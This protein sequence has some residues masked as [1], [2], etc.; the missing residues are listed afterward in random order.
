MEEDDIKSQFIGSLSDSNKADFWGDFRATDIDLREI[1]RN[2]RFRYEVFK[3]MGY[4]PHDAQKRFHDNFPYIE[5]VC[6]KKGLDPDCPHI[7]CTYRIDPK[8]PS[9]TTRVCANCKAE[10]RNVYHNRFRTV[11]AA[12]RWGKSLAV[13]KEGCLPL[14]WPG[15]NADGSLNVEKAP[16]AYVYA[17]SYAIGKHEFNYLVQGMESLGLSPERYNYSPA[18]G[19]LYARWPWG[20][21]LQVKS[22]QQPASIL[23]DEIDCALFAE[24]STLPML[25]FER[26]IRARMGSR[27]A[28]GILGSTPH[29]IG[30]FLETF[31]ERGQD[32]RDVE[33]WSESFSIM[34]NPHHPIED[35]EEARAMLDA[36]TFA[37]QYLGQFVTMAGLVFETFDRQVHV[38]PQIKNPEDLPRGSKVVFCIDFGRTAPTGALMGYWDKDG[39]FHALGE[40][41]VK[42][43]TIKTHFKEYLKDWLLKWNPEW[44]VY[45]FQQ[46]EA[47]Q[48]LQDEIFALQQM[49]LV[50]HNSLKMIPC[51][52]G[53]KAG[54]ERVRQLLHVNPETG[55]TKFY[56]DPSCV[57]LQYEFLH[58][59]NKKA[60]D[61]RIIDEPAPGH[62]HLMDAL[63][64]VAATS[65]EDAELRRDRVGMLDMED[66]Y[67]YEKRKPLS[68]HQEF[69][70]DLRRRAEEQAEEMEDD[71]DGE[72]EDEEDDYFTERTMD[73]EEW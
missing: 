37:E 43:K 58:Y 70:R 59:A 47:A 31:Y 22:W 23:G 50:D 11:I 60:P 73:Y 42:G 72:F 6:R 48:F 65:Y 7:E 4:E 15:I 2:A 54:I 62:D 16:R 19:N 39:A 53:K 14:L 57:N 5:E 35:V 61:G 55:F 12:A 56:C 33:V 68:I 17:P 26:Y 49:G 34:S 32:P 66:E 36:R 18:T 45:D 25:I 64:Y 67:I 9:Q 28:Y 71:F 41:Y 21:E 24:A 30:E 69:K 13:G 27:L 40:Y 52:K 38:K 8:D 51:K 63:E 20:A 1:K 46:V 44:I 10:F 29:G 3:E